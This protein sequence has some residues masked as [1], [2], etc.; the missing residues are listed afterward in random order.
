RVLPAELLREHAGHPARVPRAR[1]PARLR[2]AARAGLDALAFLRHLLRLRA[3]R[4]RAGPRRLRGVP[5]LGE[6]RDKKRALDGPLL[7][8]VGALNAARRANPA[9]QYVDNVTF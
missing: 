1:R 2:G 4:E 3:L 6:V 8:L 5:R 9:L 7:P